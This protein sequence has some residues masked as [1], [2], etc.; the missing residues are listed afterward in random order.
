MDHD[1]SRGS[2]AARRAL[3]QTCWAATRIRRHRHLRNLTKRSVGFVAPSGG[4]GPSPAHVRLPWTRAPPD[5]ASARVGAVPGPQ[6]GGPE[7]KLWPGLTACRSCMISTRAGSL[8]W[9][10]TRPRR[11]GQHSR[12]KGKLQQGRGARGGAGAGGT[13]RACSMQ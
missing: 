3:P 9:S 8:I 5:R 6:N 1:N 7:T 4:C 2:H 13:H 12:A 10:F 11:P